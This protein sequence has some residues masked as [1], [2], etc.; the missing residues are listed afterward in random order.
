MKIL[1]LFKVDFNK[2]RNYGLDILRACAILSVLNG[3]SAALFGIN[4]CLSQVLIFLNIEGVSLFFIL[5]GFL[6]GG[7]LIKQFEKEKATFKTLFNF[8]IRR[9]FRT[10]PAYFFVLTILILLSIRYETVYINNKALSSFGEVK[11]YYYFLA[12]FK[13]PLPD[14]FSESWS[15]SVEEWFYILIPSS[16]FILVAAFRFKPKFSLLI[17]ALTVIVCVTVFRYYR[18]SQWP[19][20]TPQLIDSNFRK[21]V[22]TRLDSLM[23]GLIGAFLSFYYQNEWKKHKKLL[24]FVGLILIYAN[25]LQYIVGPFGLTYQCVFSY[26]VESVGFLCLFPYITDLTTGNG[27]IYRT[28]TKVS[29]I[30]YSL[31]LLNYTFVKFYVIGYLNKH[32]FKS[33]SGYYLMFCQYSAFWIFTIL[34]SILLYKYLEKPAMAL[35]DKFD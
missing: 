33:L 5:S 24:F 35:R 7:I 25:L 20:I 27:F 31:Y 21:E 30:S 8:W 13:T 19:G 26:T 9:W 17:I 3:H 10:L 32:L 12:N 15:L 11:N 22:I 29:I 16:L 2:K 14:L 34:L 1:S 23:F 4:S 6:I 18:V 28:I